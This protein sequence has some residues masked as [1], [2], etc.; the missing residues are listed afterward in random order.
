MNQFASYCPTLLL[1]PSV[2]SCHSIHFSS[3]PMTS[4]APTLISI[5]GGTGFAFP[6]LL[7]LCPASVVPL[8][9]ADPLSTAG[10][11]RSS[12][13]L[14]GNSLSWSTFSYSVDTEPPAARSEPP[15]QPTTPSQPINPVLP[16]AV[17]AV[18]LSLPPPASR[19]VEGQKQQAMVAAEVWQNAH[20]SGLVISL[21][22]DSERRRRWETSQRQFHAAFTVSAPQSEGDRAAAPSPPQESARQSLDTV[23]ADGDTSSSPPSPLS[24]DMAVSSSS[25]SSSAVSSSMPDNSLLLGA[26]N[27]EMHSPPPIG[28]LKEIDARSSS[29]PIV[30]KLLLASPEHC[31]GLDDGLD[32]LDCL[33]PPAVYTPPRRGSFC[34]AVR[35]ADE[36]EPLD[37]LA[38]LQSL[39]STPCSS[40]SSYQLTPPGGTPST[41]LP[42]LPLTFAGTLIQHSVAAIRTGE[43]D[44]GRTPLCEI[45]SQHIH[46]RHQ[47]Q[48][49]QQLRHRRSSL[50]TLSTDNATAVAE[51]AALQ[52]VQQR[53]IA[54]KLQDCDIHQLP[55]DDSDG[56]AADIIV[57]QP[58]QHTGNQTRK[59]ASKR[60]RKR[61]RPAA[62]NKPASGSSSERRRKSKES[63]KENRSPQQCEQC[64][65]R[66][67][68][69]GYGTGRFCGAKCARTY[70][71][72]QR[73]DNNRH[74]PLRTTQPRLLMCAAEL[75]LTSFPLL[76]DLCDEMVDVIQVHNREEES[77]VG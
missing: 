69:S 18:T 11:A 75:S 60:K 3:R 26:A 2:R 5:A 12:S 73:S 16:P 65:R 47:Q 24:A 68:D 31:F 27:H 44:K 37:A 46:P 10:T 34:G 28:L 14:H 39:T 41:P 19:G 29:L 1:P 52:S 70:S 17:P 72:K 56:E 55:S 40:N 13:L 50:Y 32:E 67:A 64:H 71:I 45:S 33:S 36:H 51:A 23:A 42:S 48:Q 49:R 35:K 25:A 20:S 57:R 59:A 63:E 7:Q 21:K 22:E 43:V 62:S 58:A 15:H 38:Y 77:E 74:S 53:T 30:G 9:P 61:S 66:Q 76:V 4:F 54:A 8:G 6:S